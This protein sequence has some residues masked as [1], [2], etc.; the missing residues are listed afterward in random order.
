MPW[1]A[2]VD[3][4]RCL[5]W[6]GR[7]W[8][9]PRPCRVPGAVGFETPPLVGAVGGRLPQGLGA[10]LIRTCLSGHSQAQP[11]GGVR[12]LDKAPGPAGLPGSAPSHPRRAGA[13]SRCRQPLQCPAGPSLPGW[14]PPSH[15][16]SE[17]WPSGVP[18][19]RPSPWVGGVSSAEAPA[20]WEVRRGLLC[21]PRPC[22]PGLVVLL[23]EVGDG[24]PGRFTESGPPLG[25]L[26]GRSRGR[27]CAE[28]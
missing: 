15:P 6:P 22:G 5:L 3:F 1:G 21:P 25:L 11:V 14:C 17:V 24:V 12:V 27:G 8:C 2:A 18:P 13:G 4:V 28:A 10:E 9:G 19:W 23:R 16:M 20:D 26:A 7:P